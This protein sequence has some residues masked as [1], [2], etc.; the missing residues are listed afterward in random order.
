MQRNW[1]FRRRFVAVRGPTDVTAP[2]LSAPVA[3]PLGD[4][5]GYLAAITNEANGTLYWVLTTSAT[6]PSA[7]Q[8]KA[9]Q[10][11]TGAAAAAAGNQAVS[12]IGYQLITATGLTSNTAYYAYFMQQDAIGNQSAVLA[13]STFT[14]LTTG[15]S[16][17]SFDNLIAAM[18]VPPNNFRKANIAQLIQKLYASGTWAKTDV[19]WV[20]AA[21]DEQ[22][23]RLNWKSPGTFTLNAIN[24][25]AFVA[26]RGFTGN[27]SSS[28]LDTGWDRPTNGVQFTQNNAHISIYQR[29]A[30][31]S[32][33]P[34]ISD[35]NASYRAAIGGQGG[36]NRWTRLNSGTN[37]FGPA[38]GTYPQQL[39]SRR[40]DATNV[41]MLADGVQVTVPSAAASGAMNTNDIGIGRVGTGYNTGQ[42]AGNSWGAYFDD[43]EAA[44]FYT[45]WNAYMV[46]VGADT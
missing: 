17:T 14:T 26:D 24:S 12:A 18:V 3:L 21:H 36:A 13:S 29:T 15:T 23:A 27:G 7:A 45:A 19:F 38:G 2:V 39:I 6:P 25:P 44:A 20:L 4:T 34:N 10:D 35:T 33:V 22:A 40:N 9:G 37:I 11:H 43:T 28:W 1:H 42:I 41:S 31:G 46:A 8:V 16:D 32:N 5:T 30:A